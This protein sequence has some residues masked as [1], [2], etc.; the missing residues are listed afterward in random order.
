M[1][2]LHLQGGLGN[3]LFQFGA[4][5][6]A[7]NFNIDLIRIIFSENLFFQFK[8][9]KF[10]SNNLIPEIISLSH[11][12]NILAHQEILNIEDSSSPF[13]DTAILDALPNDNNYF[14][15]GYFQSCS[16]ALAIRKFF[17]N[18]SNSK[19]TEIQ[20]TSKVCIHH[21]YGD[22]AKIDVQK[23]LGLIDL[24]YYDRIF[25]NENLHGEN[26]TALSDSDFF[27][28]IYRNKNFINEFL[29][30]GDD[31]RDFNIMRSA[32]ILII[33]NSSFSLMA[34]YLNPNLKLLIRP[35]LWSRR[36]QTDELTSNSPFYTQYIYNSFIDLNE[37][38]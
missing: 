36:W 37:K 13:L 38:Y 20:N 23:E 6:R 21:R 4:A 22:Y 14:L 8:L 31:I 35:S 29:V 30:G 1:V 12:K 27:S 17:L 15:N 19:F 11:F 9:D 2:F 18:P 7:C 28:N 34:A 33:P 10:F 32:E 25:N 5:L 3:Q 16:N 26:I 24:S